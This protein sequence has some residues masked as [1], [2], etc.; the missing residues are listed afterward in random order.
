VDIQTPVAGVLGRP[1]RGGIWYDVTYADGTKA[2]TKKP[3]IATKAQALIGHQG[4]TSRITE[5]P[6]KDP[7]FGM[8]RYLDDIAEGPLPLVA[9]TGGIPMTM[10][11]GNG[12]APGIPMA[13]PRG[14]GGGRG[15]SP[16]EEARI[17]RQAVLKVAGEVV[18]GLFN[19]AGPEAADEAFAMLDKRAGELF[20]RVYGQANLAQVTPTIAT[21]PEAVAAAVNAVVGSEAVAVGGSVP[22]W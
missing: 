10:A 22:Q 7:A 1:T 15:R 12:A 20:E 14:G 13:A 18:G 16:E 11:G 9:D 4:V 8:N 3:E 5:S 21:T 17:V 2:S 6:A 19:G